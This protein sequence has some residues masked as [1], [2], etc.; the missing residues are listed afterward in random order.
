MVGRMIE[1][2]SVPETPTTGPGFVIDFV[3]VDYLTSTIL[4]ISTHSVAPRIV[5]TTPGIYHISNPAPLPLH[6]LPALMKSILNP[7]ANS[8]IKDPKVVGAVPVDVFLQRVGKVLG[9]V[10]SVD[11]ELR[12]AAL[13]EYFSTGHTMFAL[14]RTN[15][16]RVLDVVGEAVT[17]PPLDVQFL[18]GMFGKH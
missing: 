4:S 15:T 12:L 2:G 18:H 14:D 7:T 6:Q 17:C 3:P 5:P 11:N 16:D 9:K 1:S 13:Q 8:N 10:I